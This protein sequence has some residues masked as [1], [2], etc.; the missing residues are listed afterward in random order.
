MPL[1]ANATRQE[2][3]PTMINQLLDYPIAIGIAMAVVVVG[4]VHLSFMAGL[5]R[6][7]RTDRDNWHRDQERL[8]RYGA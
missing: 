6:R 4:C 8:R 3:K 7:R 1:V 5:Q 2:T